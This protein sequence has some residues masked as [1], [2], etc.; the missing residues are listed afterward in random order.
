MRRDR[1]TASSPPGCQSYRPSHCWPGLLS[2][3]G[4]ERRQGGG[5]LGLGHGPLSVGLCP[6]VP[7]WDILSVP[8]WTPW[9]TAKWSLSCCFLTCAQTLRQT[10]L[11]PA[12]EAFVQVALVPFP[13]YDVL[14][15]TRPQPSPLSTPTAEAQDLTSVQCCCNPPSSPQ[16]G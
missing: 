7:G 14:S 2:T 10:L 8:G 12:V 16:R 13:T 4:D 5:H 6:L 9:K 3:G 1:R 15:V 11:C